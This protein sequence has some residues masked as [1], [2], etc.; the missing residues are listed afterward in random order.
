MTE[1]VWVACG[2]HWREQVKGKEPQAWT[3]FHPQDMDVRSS[4]EFVVITSC[5]EG[6]NAAELL[7]AWLVAMSS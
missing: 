7:Q 1:R 6:K 5:L 3:L 2:G 4:T